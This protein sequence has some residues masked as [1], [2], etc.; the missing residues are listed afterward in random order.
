MKTCKSPTSFPIN[1]PTINDLEYCEKPA[2]ANC[3][4]CDY[5]VCLEHKTKHKEFHRETAKL[6]FKLDKKNFW[7][8]E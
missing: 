3:T 2:I 6:E 8:Y 7:G 1:L 5:P 4:T